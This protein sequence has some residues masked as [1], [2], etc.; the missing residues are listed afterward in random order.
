MPTTKVLKPIRGKRMR[1]TRLDECGVPVV[2]AATTRV[3]KGFISLGISPQYEEGESIQQA[4][5]DGD[6]E[7]NEPG[8]ASLT[9]CEVEGSMIGVDPDIVE[10]LTGNPVVLDGAGNAVGFRL[11]G[12]IPIL[13]GWGIEVW[14]GLAGQVCAGAPAYGYSLLPFLRGGQI[15]DVTIENGA[16]NLTITSNTRENPGWGEG[17]YDVVDTAAALPIV[18]GP[19]LTP[20]GPKDH[21]HMQL[22]TV[23][24]PAV[25]NGLVALAA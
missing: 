6:Y 11:Q 24:P 20:I 21:W 19:L 2:G 3:T 12:G 23:A 13:G 22:T 5:A 16:V 10:L 18:P 15:G 25:T 14:T 8:D 1:I 4:N 17:P 9:H 7:I